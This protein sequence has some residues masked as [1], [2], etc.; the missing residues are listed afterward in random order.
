MKTPTQLLNVTKW[1]KELRSGKY[2]QTQGYLNLLVDLSDQKAGFCCLGVLCEVFNAPK[3]KTYGSADQIQSY[4]AD[5]NST[6]PDIDWF[7]EV[8]G[9]SPD[10]MVLLSR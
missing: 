9:F 1:V 8:T 7:T 3:N 5:G 6:T 10:F 4:F 2:P